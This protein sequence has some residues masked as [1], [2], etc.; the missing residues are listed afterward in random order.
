MQKVSVC[1]T[2]RSKRG[3]KHVFYCLSPR[4][5]LGAASVAAG[6]SHTRVLSNLPRADTPSHPHTLTPTPCHS[7][8][9]HR[10]K[11]LKA[12][13]PAPPASRGR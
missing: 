2:K 10:Q 1:F 9:P 3:R 5:S 11:R 6:P 7:M 12:S 4:L 8:P 13:L